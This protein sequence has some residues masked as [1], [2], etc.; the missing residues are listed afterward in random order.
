MKLLVV[1]LD[2]YQTLRH[3]NPIASYV[4]TYEVGVGSIEHLTCLRPS[5]P[6]FLF[7]LPVLL[8]EPPWLPRSLSVESPRVVGTATYH[9]KK[10]LFSHISHISLTLKLR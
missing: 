2:E 8:V 7:N 9:L 6:S 1:K 4:N 5:P 3:A 10:S